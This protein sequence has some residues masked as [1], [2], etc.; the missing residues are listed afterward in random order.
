[1]V[2]SWRFRGLLTCTRKR[3]SRNIKVTLL[4]E[5]GTGL[6]YTRP[7][8]KDPQDKFINLPNRFWIEGHDEKL[9]TPEFA[10][11]LAVAREKPWSSFPAERMPEWYGL[12]ADT[13]LRGLTKIL[14]LGLVER[15]FIYR[16][17]PLDAAV[18]YTKVYEYRLVTWMRP[19]AR[20]MPA[21]AAVSTGE[22]PSSP[23]KEPTASKVGRSGS[24]RVK[25]T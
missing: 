19:K 12:S 21:A 3:G 22:H 25:K 2:I 14:D 18:G 13:T 9:D 15:R 1:M 20:T 17:A 5:D 7:D 4:R 23:P 8:G 6:P 24:R 11:L 10:M 16:P